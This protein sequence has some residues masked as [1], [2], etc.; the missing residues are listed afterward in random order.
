MVQGEERPEIDAI[1]I[2]LGKQNGPCVF[3][4]GG[5]MRRNAER[6]ATENRLDELRD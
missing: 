2:L 5:F 3:G 6:R 4:E 1:W